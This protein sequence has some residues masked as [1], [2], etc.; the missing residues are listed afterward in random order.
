VRYEPVIWKQAT[1]HRDSHI[2]F[3]RR[4]YSVPWPHIG[5]QVW[6]K[7]TPSSVM[8]YA[9]DQ[10][11]AT[12]DRRG[13][14]RRSTQPRHLPERRADLAQRSIEY[15]AERAD[16]LGEAVG[17]YIRHVVDSD[18]VLSK[19]RDVQAIVTL[20]ERYPQRRALAACRRADYYGNYT[21]QG[22]RRILNRALDLEP[23]PS[24]APT[25]GHLTQP[26][27]ARNP[28][29]QLTPAMERVRERD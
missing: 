26:R 14:K 2:Q 20:L 25:H 8:V 4:L 22:V 16:A 11:I 12:H 6:I 5:A 19:L 17:V 7:A 3:E 27:F 13:T 10:R 23:L 29:E 24:D 1:V 18:T 21:Y 15:W 28:S 9:A